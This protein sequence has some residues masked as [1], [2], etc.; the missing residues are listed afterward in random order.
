MIDPLTKFPVFF[1]CGGGGGGGGGGGEN[2][3][4]RFF[5]R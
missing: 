2:A 3:M 5:S 4:E 1:S